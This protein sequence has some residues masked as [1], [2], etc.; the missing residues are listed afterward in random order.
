MYRMF[1]RICDISLSLILLAIL[2][3]LLFLIAV[4]IKLDSFG[5]IFYQGERTGKD[6]VPFRMCKFR[7][8]VPDAD[9]KGGPSTA[10][11]DPR[12]TRIGRFL[13]KAKLDELPQLINILQGQMSFVGPRPQV[14]KYTDLYNEKEKAILSVKPGLTDFA[15]LYFFDMD[16]H[17]GSLNVDKKYAQEVE[18]KKNLL[19]IQYV[20]EK[21]VKTDFYILIKTALRFFGF[22]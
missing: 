16:A 22:H 14:K 20:K 10:L 15:S 21:G 11:G 12:L 2:S 17:L 9:L 3:P 4:F 5:P 18:P 19:R 13:R 6:G 7:T 1:K 8:M